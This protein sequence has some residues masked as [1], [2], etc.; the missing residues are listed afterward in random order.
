MCV[1]LLV[2]K[3]KQTQKDQLA[4]SDTEKCWPAGSLVGGGAVLAPKCPTT[5]Q[6]PNLDEQKLIVKFKN[7]KKK[8]Y[9]KC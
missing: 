4:T 6:H 9:K 7:I 3:A 5:P 2:L 1:L 8:I